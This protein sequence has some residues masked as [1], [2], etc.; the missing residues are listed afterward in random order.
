MSIFS[1]SDGTAVIP[2]TIAPETIAPET[3]GMQDKDRV[4][5]ELGTISRLATRR[6]TSPALAE[7][8][9]LHVLDALE[10][11]NWQ[12]VRDHAGPGPFAIYLA[13]LS[14]RLMEDFARRRFGRRR[15]PLWIRALGGIHA[16]LFRLLCL[17]RLDLNAAVELVAQRQELPD[18]DEIETAA[19][20]ILDRIIDCR[21]HQ[22]L[23]VDIAEADDCRQDHSAF[24]RFED[25]DRDCFLETL[26]SGVFDRSD[27]ARRNRTHT[28]LRRLRLELSA[29]ERLLLQLCYRDNLSVTRAGELLDLN[30]HQV[31]GRLRR[32]LARLRQR[33][34]QA[35]LAAELRELLD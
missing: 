27:T 4:L 29:E 12:R 19:W 21:A 16:L 24:N 22:A 32:L 8:A 31:H 17:E 30:R 33:L 13:S 6:F 3:I 20:T 15:P 23:E 26:F 9:V 18:R 28:A 2:S 10:K 35:G 11:D 7:E 34:E 5:A 1:A 25:D 14:W